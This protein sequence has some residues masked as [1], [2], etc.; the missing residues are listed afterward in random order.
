MHVGAALSLS[1]HH[2]R[3]QATHTLC[4]SF[5]SAIIPSSQRA[6]H[7]FL[8]ICPSICPTNNLQTKYNRTLLPFSPL[9][10]TIFSS[11]PLSAPQ[12]SALC[13]GQE[14]MHT[15][16][17]SCHPNSFSLLPSNFLTIMFHRADLI[18]RVA[19]LPASDLAALYLPSIKLIGKGAGWGAGI[20]HN[21]V[22]THSFH[23][24]R[25]PKSLAFSSLPHLTFLISQ[26]CS[27]SV[28]PALKLVLTFLRL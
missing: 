19:K 3:K 25:L 6:G 7:T 14:Y 20:S 2:C 5:P 24:C 26:P 13:D 10:C 27:V 16:F 11:H 4:P 15:S 28:P 18:C 12:P 1:R 8:F 22:L 17:P 21:H 9:Y 23:L